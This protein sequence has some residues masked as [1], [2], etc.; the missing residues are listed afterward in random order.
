[1]LEKYR[2]HHQALL[3]LLEDMKALGNYRPDETYARSLD[4]LQTKL[5]ENAFYLVVLGEF[6]RGKSTLINALLK[7]E[8]LPTAVVPLTSIVTLI[9]HGDQERI[10]VGFDSGKRACIL[11]EELAEYVTERGNPKNIKGVNRVEIAFPSD[12]LRGGVHLIDTPGVGSIFENNTRATYDFLPKVDAALFLFTVDP[13]ISRSEL[14]FLSDVRQYVDK[15]FFVQNKIDYLDEADRLESMVFSKEVIEAALHDGTATIHPLS[16]KLALEGH[17]ES[18]AGKIQTSYLPDLEAVL[19]DFLSHQKGR[20][21]LQSAL[22]NARKLAGDQEFA[23]ELERK[24]V[25]TPLQ[26]LQEKIALFERQLERIQ[27]EKEDNGYFFEA[28]MKRIMDFLDHH[29]NRLRNSELPRLIEE[30]KAESETAGHGG[31]QQYVETMKEILN[32]GIVHT[33][34]QWITDQEQRLNEEFARISKQYSDRA[35]AIIEDLVEVSSKLFG[36]RMERFESAETIHA[37]TRFY[38][39]LGDPPRFF[40]LAGAIDFFSQTLLPKGISRRKV[41]KDL[42]KKLPERVDANCGRVRADFMRRI[43][44][45]FLAFRWNLN[46]KIDATA[47]SIRLALEQACEMH[48]AGSEQKEKLIGELDR[49]RRKVFQIKDQLTQLDTELAG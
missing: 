9:H 40:D 16:A 36:I 6:K 8:L 49:Q 34:D 25:A 10:E 33:F 31:I 19:T 4:E 29:L 15:I 20:I 14:E 46:T 18:N 21:L 17:L 2:A 41:Y 37:D 42:L 27:R 35:N 43:R 22:Q 32:Q 44:E 26:E 13:P 5:R 39:L 1:M 48:Q 24:A 3:E 23:V 12:K 11:R 47:E 28:E 30:F 45:S 7:T 38:Y